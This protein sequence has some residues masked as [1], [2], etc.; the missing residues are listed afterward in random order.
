MHG[1]RASQG[2]KGSSTRA[3]ADRVL[4]PTEPLDSLLIAKRKEAFL[5]FLPLDKSV[6]RRVWT[7]ANSRDKQ[8]I[9]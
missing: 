8:G 1:R 9:G 2:G 3:R 7:Q 6:A 5:A 4:S